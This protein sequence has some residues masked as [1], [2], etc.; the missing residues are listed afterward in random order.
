MP[1][2]VEDTRC[3]ELVRADVSK[4]SGLVRMARALDIG[5]DEICAVGDEVNDLPMLRRAAIG[6]AMGS[7]PPHV[8]DAAHRITDPCDDDGVARVVDWLLRARK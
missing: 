6:V 4:W 7:A 3:R 2:L 1:Y 5:R 8:R